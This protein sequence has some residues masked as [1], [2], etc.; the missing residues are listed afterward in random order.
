MTQPVAPWWDQ[1]LFGIR[2]VLAAG[3]ELVQQRS[4]IN[5]IGANVVDNPGLK[6]TDVTILG[7]LPSGAAGGDLVGNYPDP[8]VGNLAGN[9]PAGGELDVSA[10]QVQHYPNLGAN[11]GKAAAISSIAYLKTTDDGEDN[12]VTFDTL[13]NASRR[14]DCVVTATKKGDGSGVGTLQTSWTASAQYTRISGAA[15]KLGEHVSDPLVSG[16]GFT[17]PHF[18]T[19]GTNA[20]LNLDPGGSTTGD[21]H[22]TV[23]YTITLSESL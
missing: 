18:T 12:A 16:T 9:D 10:N 13:V 8:Y 3:V 15:V 6:C 20:L 11:T 19:V 5:F 7:G 2:T 17:G 4:R 14:I 21:V 22:W 1:F 23:N